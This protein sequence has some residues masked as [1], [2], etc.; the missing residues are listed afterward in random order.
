M[1]N[2]LKFYEIISSIQDRLINIEIALNKKTMSADIARKHIKQIIILT[3]RIEKQFNIDK[4]LTVGIKNIAKDLSAKTTIPY[5]SYD[6][7]CEQ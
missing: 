1:N 7:A 3:K 4:A 5:R 6:Y 2:D